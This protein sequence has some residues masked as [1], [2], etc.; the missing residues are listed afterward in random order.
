[1]RQALKQLFAWALCFGVIRASSIVVSYDSYLN[2]DAGVMGESL[3]VVT[4]LVFIMLLLLLRLKKS[5]SPSCK[6]AL[7]M[8]ALTICVLVS[9]LLYRLHD[10]VQHNLIWYY[11]LLSL[12]FISAQLLN[13]WILCSIAQLSSKSSLVYLFSGIIASELITLAASFLIAPMRSLMLVIFLVAIS[14]LLLHFIHGLSNSTTKASITS[15]SLEL[16]NSYSTHL[17]ESQIASRPSYLAHFFLSILFLAL[18]CGIARGFPDGHP[19]SFSK[20]A[21]CTYVFLTIMLCLAWIAYI[22]GKAE[23]KFGVGSWLIA[24][25]LLSFGILSFAIYPQQPQ[26]GAI[27]ITT[28]NIYLLGIMWYTMLLLMKK[29]RFRPFTYFVICWIAY[30]IPRAIGRIGVYQIF[31]VSAYPSLALVIMCLMALASALSLFGYLLHD[32]WKTLGHL[33]RLCTHRVLSAADKPV[34]SAEPKTHEILIKLTSGADLLGLNSMPESHEELRRIAM[35]RSIEEMGRMF[36]LSSREQEVLSLFAS[37]LTQKAVAQQLG[38]SPA[39]VHSHIK[40]IYEKTNLHSRQEVL[41]F[42]EEHI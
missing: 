25:I 22:S 10:L 8:V 14:P 4:S 41:N 38:L 3:S 23:R 27:F 18:P 34:D 26:G 35:Q 42:I 29:G 1:M 32:A 11:L 21:Q 12:Q 36:H 39:T 31:D 24:F 33:Q 19:I 30:M 6:G 20:G 2:S 13:F 7:P 5:Y 9:V 37:G 28:L 17:E 40:R 16:F 15:Q